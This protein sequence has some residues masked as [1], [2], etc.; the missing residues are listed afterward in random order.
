M[1]VTSSYYTHFVPLA[2]C[3][4]CVLKSSQA[5]TCQPT[6]LTGAGGGLWAALL[7]LSQ[8]WPFMSSPSPAPLTLTSPCTNVLEFTS[9][10]SRYWMSRFFQMSYYFSKYLSLVYWSDEEN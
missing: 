6:P 10:I 5:S 1:S 8:Q 4:L 3:L 9:P 7:S 2:F